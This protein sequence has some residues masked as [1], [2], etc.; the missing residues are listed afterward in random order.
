MNPNL[1]LLFASIF[2]VSV[3]YAILSD[4]TSLRIPN[5]VSIALIAAFAVYALL[6]GVKTP[7]WHHIAL[8]GGVL[9]CFLGSLQSG[10]SV[11]G[12]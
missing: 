6:G 10:R 3:I 2:V 7:L 4:Y 1:E 9:A 12:T 8:A 5:S 11:P